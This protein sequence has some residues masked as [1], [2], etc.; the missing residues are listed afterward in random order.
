MVSTRQMSSVGGGTNGG[1]DGAGPSHAE[2][3]SV[4]RVTR[5]SSTLMPGGSSPQQLSSGSSR[6]TSLVTVQRTTT[7]LFDLPVELIE[8]I[9]RYVGFKNIAHLRM[10]SII[11][12]LLFREL[13]IY[14]KNKIL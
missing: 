12:C 8:K 3:V 10:V 6:Y 1:S 4:V 11:V 2:P 7:N 13:G 14:Y 5:H 9:L